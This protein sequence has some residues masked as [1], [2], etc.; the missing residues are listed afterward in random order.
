[1]NK[2]D[3]DEMRDEIANVSDPEYRQKLLAELQN[4]E[5]WKT[6]PDYNNDMLKKFDEWESEAQA[7]INREI[8]DP[9]IRAA[10]LRH[11]GRREFNLDGAEDGSIE[12]ED[13]LD[14]TSYES[15]FDKKSVK[16]VKLFLV[17]FI[18]FLVVLFPVI[19][20]FVD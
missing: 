19:L 18:L 7:I 10:I 5:E 11:H 14:E 3:F 13:G 8:K 12:I 15:N 4:Y 6:G 2:A 1:M 20:L 17:L 16:G 9:K